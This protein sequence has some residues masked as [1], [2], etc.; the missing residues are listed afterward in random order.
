MVP[1]GY[2]STVHFLPLSHSL[3]V[4]ATKK[5]E[6]MSAEDEQPAAEVVETPTTAPA[7]EGD[8]TATN[9]ETEDSKKKNGRRE[10]NKRDETPI[11]E[12]FDLTQPIPRVRRILYQANVAR[13]WSTRRSVD[14]T[15]FF[16]SFLSIC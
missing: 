16:L 10:F 6:T 9:G 15:A 14:A 2:P 7:T 1:M 13:I 3:C 8:A 4:F 11:E 5:S 12:L